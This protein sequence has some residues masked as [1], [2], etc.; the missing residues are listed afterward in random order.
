MFS[1]ETVRDAG[2]WA[3]ELYAV[4]NLHGDEEGRRLPRQL[5]PP[6]RLPLHLHPRRQKPA[7]ARGGR[8]PIQGL[9]ATYSYHSTFL[10]GSTGR[11]GYKLSQRSIAGNHFANLLTFV[12]TYK[13]AQWLPIAIE[14]CCLSTVL[15]LREVTHPL[16]KI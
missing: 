11:G 4:Y 12:I 15:A 14:R 6:A 13:F 7:R 9:P 1:G 16:R 5:P 10:T 2:G 8:Q 3:G